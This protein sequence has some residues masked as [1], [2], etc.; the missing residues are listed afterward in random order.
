[1]GEI[2]DEETGFVVCVLFG[3]LGEAYII[4]PIIPIAQRLLEWIIN[5]V[6]NV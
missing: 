3:R 2:L 6:E 5:P 4:D 1:L